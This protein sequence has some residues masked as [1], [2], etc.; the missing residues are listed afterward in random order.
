[1]LPE[2]EAGDKIFNP[3]LAAATI[4]RIIV[5]LKIERNPT[6]GCAVMSC[7]GTAVA[8]HSTV[9]CCMSARPERQLGD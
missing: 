1:M 4:C 8:L 9:G 7:N 5:D 2:D 6:R 3:A